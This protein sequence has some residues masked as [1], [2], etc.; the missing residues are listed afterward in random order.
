MTTAE[1]QILLDM[2]KRATRIV[3]LG[4]EGISELDAEEALNAA[5]DV[6]KSALNA[7]LKIPIF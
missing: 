5:L 6:A 4:A 1:A 3:L 7:A 2:H